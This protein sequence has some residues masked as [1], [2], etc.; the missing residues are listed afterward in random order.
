MTIAEEA[1][2]TEG[3][4]TSDQEALV[5]RATEMDLESLYAQVGLL[6]QADATPVGP[7]ELMLLGRQWV[8][9]HWDQARDAVC[10]HRNSITRTADV[11][12]TASALL[13]F[14]GPLAPSVAGALFAAI[15]AKV[16]I[17]ILCRDAG[18]RNA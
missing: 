15:I 5:I 8:S 12:A 14:L 18:E 6:A 17:E 3:E 10:P 9:E 1:H 2:M 13:P 11:A 16:G 4:P 7:S